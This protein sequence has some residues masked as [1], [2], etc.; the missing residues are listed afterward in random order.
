MPRAV[1]LRNRQ[2]ACNKAKSYQREKKK[3]LKKR[4]SKASNLNERAVVV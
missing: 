3:K 4:K 2:V 1:K